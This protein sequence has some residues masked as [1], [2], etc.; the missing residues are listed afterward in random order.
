M[1]FAKTLQFLSANSVKIYTT[2]VTQ[3]LLKNP[4]ISALVLD[5]I[6]TQKERKKERDSMSTFEVTDSILAINRDQ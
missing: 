6:Q 4:A 2:L 3:V 5:L 1:L